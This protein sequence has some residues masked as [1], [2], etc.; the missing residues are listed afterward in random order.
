MKHV[1]LLVKIS[2]RGLPL[3]PIRSHPF[4]STRANSK[5]HEEEID[6]IRPKEGYVTTI[7]S[8]QIELIQDVQPHAPLQAY[9][10]VRPKVEVTLT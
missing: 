6:V 4:K 9:R 10:K 5:R 7:V 3:F 8:I 1:R 2:L